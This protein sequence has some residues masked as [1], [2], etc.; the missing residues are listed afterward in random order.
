MLTRN[1]KFLGVNEE[2]TTRSGGCCGRKGTT[3]RKRMYK[4]AKEYD[5]PHGKMFF[6]YGNVY[7]VDEDTFTFLMAMNLPNSV[8]FEEVV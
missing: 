3:A 2:V 5:T 7:E 1:V 4:A 8:L 6:V